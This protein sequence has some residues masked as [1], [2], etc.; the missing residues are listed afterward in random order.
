MK[1]IGN[2][3]NII[4]WDDVITS[5][6]NVKPSYVG[7]SH[8]KG[9]NIPGLNEVLDIWERAK[10][11]TVH[12]DPNGTVGWDMFISGK[13]FD[14]RITEKFLEFVGLTEYTTCWISRINIGRMAPWHWDVNDDEEQLSQQPE[15]RRF[16]CHIGK[17][18]HGHIFLLEDR[19]FYNQ[20]QGATYE[21][22]SRKLW[23]AGMNSG[24]TPKYLLN[25]W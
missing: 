5:L 10:F 6:E 24:L 21:W 11:K 22:P 13:D 17:P 9:D 4:D 7:P 16:H 20:E 19:C 8:K 18:R 15:K 25:L 23:H 2:C 3:S 12:E 1:Y 14:E